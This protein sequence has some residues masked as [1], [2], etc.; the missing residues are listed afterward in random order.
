MSPSASTEAPGQSMEQLGG[1]IGDPA[2]GHAVEVEAKAL[3]AFDHGTPAAVSRCATSACGDGFGCCTRLGRE[4]RVE[5]RCI[6][7]AVRAALSIRAQRSA[8]ASV[9]RTS[10][11]TS[12]CVERR[13]V[14]RLGEACQARRPRVDAPGGAARASPRGASLR[15]TA[16]ATLSMPPIDGA[17]W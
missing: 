13:Q 3:R 10:T 17:A 6:D 7:H 8:A 11:G 14:R 4:A 9:G 5:H 1:P 2:L 16:M 15:S 12:D